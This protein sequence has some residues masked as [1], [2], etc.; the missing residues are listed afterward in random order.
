MTLFWIMAALMAVVA[1]GFLLPP[2][3]RRSREGE[4]DAREAAIEVY[5]RR[6]TE[7]QQDLARGHLNELQH[8][9]ARLE[10]EAAM[11]ADLPKSAPK[12]PPAQHPW[13]ALVLA[14]AV[15]IGSLALYQQLGAGPEASASLAAEEVSTRQRAVLLDASVRLRSHLNQDPADGRAWQLLGRTYSAL[16]EH[17]KAAQ[18]LG[19]A[20]ALLGDSP[21]LLVYYARA[22]AAT[23]DGRLAGRPAELLGR[24][25]AMDPENREALWLSAAVALEAGRFAEARRLFTR[26]AALMPPGSNEE[27]I[28]RAHIE[29]LGE[30]QNET[31]AGPPGEYKIKVLVDLDPGLRQRVPSDATVFVFARAPQGP[32]IPLAVARRRAGDLPLTVILS[33]AEAMQPSFRLSNFTVAVVG[34][35]V[36][37]SGDPTPKSGDLEGIS[38]TL[39]A[40]DGP[41]PA[42]VRITIDRVVP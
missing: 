1:L 19:E 39:I 41:D 7:L 37:L 2:L 34:A 18:A 29:R 5:R 15:P 35:R 40:L 23:H 36:S 28:V 13:T 20:H 30:R 12:Q 9:E 25:L 14:V 38:G 24:A 3:L 33:D 22:L 21:G 17:E 26:L 27:R 31:S 16:E 8:E 32:Q 4:V 42:E 11:A 10:L 6:L